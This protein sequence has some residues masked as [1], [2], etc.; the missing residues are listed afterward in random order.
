ME[1][2]WLDLYGTTAVAA[3]LAREVLT[4]SGQFLLYKK[5][6]PTGYKQSMEDAKVPL[7]KS[8][9]QSSS[10]PQTRK[11][12][13]APSPIGVTADS[14]KWLVSFSQEIFRERPRDPI[15]IL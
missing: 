13:P 11:T 8:T 4:N 6:T 14:Q 12:D 5:L 2:T 3:L 9:L 10:I 15:E 7:A 1:E